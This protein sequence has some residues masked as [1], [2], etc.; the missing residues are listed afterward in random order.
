MKS[1]FNK[2][3]WPPRN[4]NLGG[5]P[6][7]RVWKW[8]YRQRASKNSPIPLREIVFKPTLPFDSCAIA[9]LS[10]WASSRTAP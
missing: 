4:V 2:V 7:A 9:F 8:V 6:A 3:Q 1:T 10:S 5:W